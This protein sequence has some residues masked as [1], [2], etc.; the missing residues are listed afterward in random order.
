MA[1]CGGIL[2]TIQHREAYLS[3]MQNGVLW[4]N[5]EHLFCGEEFRPAYDWLTVQMKQHICEP[6]EGVHYPVW[7]WHT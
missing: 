5:E 4:A 6:P 1:V 2:W 3:L 7:L